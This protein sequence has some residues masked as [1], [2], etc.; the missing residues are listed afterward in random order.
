MQTWFNL[1]LKVLY[2]LS[3]VSEGY[4]CHL[5]LFIYYHPEIHKEIL[6]INYSDSDQIQV[7]WKPW[8]HKNEEIVYQLALRLWYD[9]YESF[10]ALWYREVIIYKP[11]SSCH[12]VMIYKPY[13]WYHEVM[14]YKPYNWYHEFMIYKPYIWYHKFIIYKSYIWYHEVM[15]YKAYSWHHEV[16]IYK[17]YSWYH[18]VM[19][20]KPYSW[21]HEN[22]TCDDKYRAELCYKSRK[23]PSQVQ[24][25]WQAPW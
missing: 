13:S 1:F 6:P 20:Y 17:P 12:E 3:F 22:R 23:Q 15:I 11:Y 16:K 18:E 19:I 7:C 8:F 14:I 5:I 25:G 4:F 9:K 24:A 21:Y 2:R 10:A